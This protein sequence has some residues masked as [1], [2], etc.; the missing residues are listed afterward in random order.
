MSRHFLD[1]IRRTQHVVRCVSLPA[2]VVVAFNIPSFA[3][4]Q[5]ACPPSSFLADSFV[6]P[7]CEVSPLPEWSDTESWVW[8]RICAAKPAD[9]NKRRGNEW[10]DPRDPN[11]YSKFSNGHRTLRWSFLSTILSDEQYFRAITEEGIRICG[12]YF[13]DTVRL[14]GASIPGPLQL[15][16][17]FFAGLVY[18]NDLITAKGV[19]LSGSKF[20]DKLFLTGASIPHVLDLSNASFLY[21]EL[22]ELNKHQSEPASI[23]LRDSSVKSHIEMTNARA[24]NF[25]IN[26]TTLKYLDLTG[27]KIEGKLSI[28]ANWKAWKISSDESHDPLLILRDVRVRN[29]LATPD[30]WVDNL[31]LDLHGFKF[32][33][34]GMVPE[35]SDDFWDAI[36]LLDW[37]AKDR[38][39][40][41]QP[42]EHL[43]DR[44]REAGKSNIADIVLHAKRMR[45][46][47]TNELF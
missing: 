43:E 16:E 29:L 1:S 38:S 13:S 42:Y 12:A 25:S 2:L 18:M 37:L 45:A 31:V 9:L 6:A 3:Q 39:Y 21:I 44:L 30:D 5:G 46:S 34:S 4:G 8:N 10:L 15:S 27:T 35:Y 33:K 36:S 7:R 14:N 47:D 22:N 11:D 19:S 26:G 41:L 32:D 23:T 40:S 20:E 24:A 17:S 28:E